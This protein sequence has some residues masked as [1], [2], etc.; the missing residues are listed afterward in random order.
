MSLTLQQQRFVLEYLADPKRNATQAAIR[1]G[2]NPNRAKVTASEFLADPKIQA[3][4]DDQLT[5]HLRSLN[6]DAEM[7]ISGIVETIEKAKAAGQGA[8]QSQTILRGYELLGRY[9]GI[10]T[11]KVDI[12]A[13]EEL[14]ERL[15]RG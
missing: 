6:V 14:I 9:L 13:D 3:A 7:V 5:K 2:Y 15:H 11:D 12:K 8:W 10:F 4:I 1:A